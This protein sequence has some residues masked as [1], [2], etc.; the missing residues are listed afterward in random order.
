M[1]AVHRLLRRNHKQITNT[2]KRS[3]SSK[4]SDDIRSTLNLP[5]TNFPMRASAS[6]RERHLVARSTHE[7]YRWQREKGNATT[8]NT[9]ESTDNHFILHDG[10]PYANG[11]LHIGH[12]LNKVLKD[13]MNRFALL[14]GKI[15]DYRPGWDCHGLPIELKALQTLPNNPTTAGTIDENSIAPEPMIIREHAKQCALEAIS[16]QRDDFWRWGVMADW[17]WGKSTEGPMEAANNGSIYVTMA[18]K[19][20]AAQL[21]VFRDMLLSGFVHRGLKPVHWSPSSKTALAEAELEYSDDHVSESV[22]VTYPVV[23]I[24]STRNDTSDL[25]GEV[26]SLIQ[27]DQLEALIWTTTPWTLPANMA[28]CVHPDVEYSIIKVEDGNLSANNCSTGSGNSKFLLVA[29]DLIEHL[30]SKINK[31]RREEKCDSNVVSKWIHTGL[32]CFGEDLIGCHAIPPLGKNGDQTFVPFIPGEHVTVDS[33]TGIVHTAPGHGQDDFVAWS[34]WTTSLTKNIG[35]DIICPVDDNGR[36]TDDIG[37]QTNGIL[38][39]FEGRSVVDTLVGNDKE[40]GVSKD[41]VEKLRDIGVLLY[42][43]PHSHRYPYD[44][45]TKQPTIVRATT[46]WFV[47]IGGPLKDAA[48]KSLLKVDMTPKA[49][50]NRL[51][52]MI[53]G[54]DNWC[55]SR[56][57][58]WGVPIPVFYRTIHNDED[59]SGGEKEEVLATK[60][61]LD[62]IISLV[63]ENGTNCWWEM[64]THELLP[65]SM[66]NE[67][68]EGWFKCTDT[69]DV[70][71][72]SGCSWA[73][74]KEDSVLK[75]PADVYL[76]GSDQ[77]RGWF[78]SSL[79]TNVASQYSHMNEDNEYM[80][81]APYRRL[82]THGFVLD[83]N[84]K[85][86]SKSLGNVIDPSAIIEGGINR[87]EQ[88]AIDEE[89]R[90]A[91]L[92][93][94]N[95]G[96]G[97]IAKSKKKRKK[98]KV[99]KSHR[100]SPYGAD[101]LRLWAASSDYTRD[102]L[103]GPKVIR[104]ASE[105]LRKIRN[106]ARFILGNIHDFD[107]NGDQIDL[108]ELSPIDRLLLHRTAVFL[109]NTRGHYDAFHF[110][111]V[112]ECVQQYV[113]NDLSSFYFEIVKDTLYT[114]GSQ[115]IGRR[116]VQTT[117]YHALGALLA[118]ISPIIPFTAEDI[119]Q[120]QIMGIEQ[121]R[122]EQCD[123]SQDSWLNKNDAV[124]IDGV[125]EKVPGESLF[126]VLSWSPSSS[127]NEDDINNMEEYAWPV[128][129]SEKFIDNSLEKKWLPVSQLRERVQ[130]TLEIA[131]KEE[132]AIGNSL[133]AKIE[134]VGAWSEHP[135]ATKDLMSFGSLSNI[136]VVSQVEFVDLDNATDSKDCISY[137]KATIT[138]VSGMTVDIGIRVVTPSGEK[139]P[140]CWKYAETVY[141]SGVHDEVPACGCEK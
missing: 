14:Q 33:G 133:D 96:E 45:R 34:N 5:F 78:Q 28:L 3:F 104:K 111:K 108:N 10:P 135:E 85:K 140:R 137:E 71:F 66:S 102:V 77:H 41:I 107:P 25:S 50:Q 55:I 83:E 94:G 84:G 114:S 93:D 1:L 106:T 115:S 52:S 81:E 125:Y 23:S 8:N 131:R 119:Y 134:L 59:D 136:F 19:Y 127:N 112:I 20:E 98:K 40:R 7:L 57:R 56:Q 64:S 36:Y 44:W 101:V 75:R 121:L 43:E 46:Q 17:D 16:S 42:H 12:L 82:V 120:Y 105:S 24:S 74:R 39:G 138:L 4:S 86:M 97:I 141:K 69:L 95:R 132:K 89:K 72:D 80:Y 91:T 118:V 61:S 99:K 37:M 63:K 29:S 79:L 48:S 73:A 9:T 22:Y 58:N 65:P 38:N 90:E 11:D 2:S 116:R 62:H 32:K 51:Q 88:A 130:Y 126:R 35:K 139:C 70:W 92:A 54:R 109:E 6:V 26:K 53:E 13:F 47:D 129:R 128:M 117:L 31:E 87:S 21:S 122:K 103:I 100:W 123:R 113:S 27:N 76:E 67:E 60:E 49:S 18:P 68:K 124:L 110:R 30:E 15:V